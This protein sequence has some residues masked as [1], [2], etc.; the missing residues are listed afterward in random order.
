M[1]GEVTGTEGDKTHPGC[2]CRGLREA[3]AESS[4]AHGDLS[5]LTALPCT[6]PSM[7]GDSLFT[8]KTCLVLPK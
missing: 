4:S 6:D 2:L 1:E 7:P 8:S 5:G 3:G